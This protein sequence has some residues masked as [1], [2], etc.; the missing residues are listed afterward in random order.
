VVDSLLCAAVGG[1]EV[2]ASTVA[3]SVIA[4]ASQFYEVDGLCKKLRILYLE[5]HCNAGT[6]PIAPL[7][8]QAGNSDICRTNANGLLQ[9]FV[10]YTADQGIAAD[11]NLL[12]HGKFFTGSP[13]LAALSL[14][15]FV[16]LMVQILESIRSTLQ[17]IPC[18][19]PNWSLTRWAIS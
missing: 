9:N 1:T 13:S 15:H 14:E 17:P 5:I 11:L 18:P 12:F 2:A 16:L 8:Q 4:G 19:G 3:Q 7:L 10:H 6:D